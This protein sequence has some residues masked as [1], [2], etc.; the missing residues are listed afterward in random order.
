MLTITV[1]AKRTAK[2]VIITVP[3]AFTGCA[4]YRVQKKKILNTI[5]ESPVLQILVLRENFAYD[6]DKYLLFW[7]IAFP[8]K[9]VIENII[10]FSSHLLRPLTAASLPYPKRLSVYA[11]LRGWRD[12]NLFRRLP[13]KRYNNIFFGH[14]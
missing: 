7:F 8:K 3:A 6:N 10:F 2:L 5:I 9:N 14:Y 13:D 11:V 1:S 12:G 4:I